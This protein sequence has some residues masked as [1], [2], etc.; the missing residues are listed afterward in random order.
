MARDAG[1]AGVPRRGFNGFD[2]SALFKM[3][4]VELATL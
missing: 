2:S 3:L 1:F 4:S